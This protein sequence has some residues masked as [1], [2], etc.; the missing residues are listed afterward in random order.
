[1]VDF[2]PAGR[3]V[4]YLCERSTV[5]LGCLSDSLTDRAVTY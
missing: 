2:F 3:H 1:M 5:N 4:S